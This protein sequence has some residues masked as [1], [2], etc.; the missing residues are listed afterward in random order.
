MVVKN[1]KIYIIYS[2]EKKDM[3]YRQLDIFPPQ[4]G[5]H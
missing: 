2:L 5:L 1:L 3:L 4:N